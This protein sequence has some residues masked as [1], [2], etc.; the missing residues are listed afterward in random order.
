MGGGKDL[1]ME[2][3]CRIVFLSYV[4]DIKDIGFSDIGEEKGR[5]G[6]AVEQ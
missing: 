2:W 4:G 6:V 5:N 3:G 1:G